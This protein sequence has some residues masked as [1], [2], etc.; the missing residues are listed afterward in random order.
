M[1]KEV[2][3]EIQLENDQKLYQEFLEAWRSGT[4][5]ES[6]SV[7]QRVMQISLE[8][9]K[10][11]NFEEDVEGIRQSCFLALAKGQYKGKS[12]LKIY[13]WKIMLNELKRR[14]GKNKKIVEI[15]D[16]LIDERSARIEEEVIRRMSSE[17]HMEKLLASRPELQRK[18]IQLIIGFEKERVP[19]R[20]EIIREI[21]KSSEGKYS[22]Y[23]IE[24]AFDYFVVF[25]EGEFNRFVERTRELKVKQKNV[26]PE[27]IDL[28][29][30][31]NTIFSADERQRY[32]ELYA[33]FQKE[34][35]TEKERNELLK[36]SDKF[37]ILNAKRLAYLGELAKLREQ[38]LEEVIKDLGVKS[39][40]EAK[41]WETKLPE[42][43][44]DY[45]PITR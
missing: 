41:I 39:Q 9:C 38:S 19:K 25:L 13:I 29:H 24:R 11:Y 10:K 16:K 7:Y 6:N 20:R 28:L 12:S 26:L 21:Q 37:E 18:I 32:N 2:S 36:L 22:R 15:D 30:Q 35:L 43:D 23:T 34:N 42:N 27:E 4:L 14:W 33:K 5:D 45:R 44:K 17:K 40:K 1:E 3:E 8:I 31:I